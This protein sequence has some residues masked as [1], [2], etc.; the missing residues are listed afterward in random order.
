MKIPNC[1]DPAEQED[2]RQ[3]DWDRFADRLPVCA[4]CQKKLF[5][6]DKFHAAGCMCVCSPCVEELNENIEIVEDT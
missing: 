6:G 5:P 4:L 1:Y 2:H 3:A